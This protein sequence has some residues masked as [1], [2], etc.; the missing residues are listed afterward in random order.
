ELADHVQVAELVF[1]EALPDGLDAR[2]GFCLHAA[3]I[4]VGL[5]GLVQQPL[6]QRR[7]VRVDDGAVLGDVLLFDGGNLRVSGAG[8]R[9][10]K[11]GTDVHVVI[12][13]LVFTGHDGEGVHLGDGRGRL[14]IVVIAQV[15]FRMAVFIGSG[16]A[17]DDVRVAL[18]D[19]VG[20]S[21]FNPIH[22]RRVA[23]R[24][25]AVFQL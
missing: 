24:V 11:G 9:V 2:I 6:F 15:V 8:H 21:A 4:V 13:G 1:Q 14:A 20:V 10:R 5:V 16:S 7:F 3:V 19:V 18:Q 25:V 22:E 12:P 17:G 23:V